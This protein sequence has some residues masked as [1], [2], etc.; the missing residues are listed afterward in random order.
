MEQ[1]YNSDGNITLKIL[2]VWLGLVKSTIIVNNVKT[3]GDYLDVQEKKQL[4]IPTTCKSW[5]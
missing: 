1:K 3:Q 5:V 2:F 4:N